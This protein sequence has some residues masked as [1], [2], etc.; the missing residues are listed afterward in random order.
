MNCLVVSLPIFM[1][2]SAWLE[3]LTAE[4]LTSS[5]FFLVAMLPAGCSLEFPVDKLI[6]F[7]DVKFNVHSVCLNTSFAFFEGY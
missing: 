2:S 3:V 7:G 6:K 1:R 5:V 4:W